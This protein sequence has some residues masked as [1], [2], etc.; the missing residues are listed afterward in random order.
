MKYFLLVL[1]ALL[2]FMASAQCGLSAVTLKNGTVLKGII[3]QMSTDAI[4][5]DISG[6]ETKI[7]MNDVKQIEPI[8]IAVSGNQEKSPVEIQKVAV[9]DPW[10]F[11]KGFLLA[12]GNSVYVYSANSDEDPSAK[13]DKAGANAIKAL[14]KADGFWNVVDY[15][16][17]AHFTINY[18]VDTSRSDYAYLSISS[19]RTGKSIIIDNSGA[20]ESIDN[21]RELAKKFYKRGIVPFQ[22]KIEKR[23]LPPKTIADFTIK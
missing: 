15:M 5:I 9:S 18:I 8:E 23:K 19:W 21:N 12:K 7:T 11:F 3:K 1:F 17:E 16:Q 4:T 10:K 20:N 2:P 6:I 14:L 13:Y 22:R